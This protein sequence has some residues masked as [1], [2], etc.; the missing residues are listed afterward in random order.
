MLAADEQDW[1]R[2]AAQGDRAAFAWLVQQ[3]QT[4]VFN[5]A[6][7][8]LGNRRDAED[9]AQEAFLRAFRNMARF[10]SQRPFRPWIK[11]ITTN[12]C[13]N[14]LEAQRV[15][16]AIT[17]ADVGNTDNPANLDEWA[18]HN[19]TPEQRMLAQEQAGD[20]RAAILQLPP[21]YRA[22]IELRHFQE[23][24]YEEMAVVLERPLSSVKSDLFRARK[25]L[26]DL[27]QQT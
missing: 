23:L 1:Q 25:K 5:V 8:L 26:G 4:A 19:P 12:L 20:I 9:A 13:L 10:D 6:Y 22:V 11:R 7:R 2:R 24:S 21:H 18:H 17:E 3:H 15:R 16:P 27:L 14:R